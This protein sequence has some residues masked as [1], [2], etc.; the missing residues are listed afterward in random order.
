MSKSAVLA[1]L[2]RPTWWCLPQ[3]LASEQVAVPRVPTKRARRSRRSRRDERFAR[4]NPESAGCGRCRDAVTRAATRPSLFLILRAPLASLRAAR[5]RRD[6]S[7]WVPFRSRHGTLEV[8]SLISLRVDSRMRDRDSSKATA[9][10]LSR[11]RRLPRYPNRRA[12]ED[13]RSPRKCQMRFLDS[14]PTAPQWADL[15]QVTYC[16]PNPR[17]RPI[18]GAHTPDRSGTK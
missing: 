16:H 10:P 14:R 18:D 3:G 2:R 15:Q 5:K 7:G 11:Q 4:G 1:L 9:L 13:L 12:A 17:H 6:L 8:N